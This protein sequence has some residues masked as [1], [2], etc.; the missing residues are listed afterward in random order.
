MQDMSTLELQKLFADKSCI[1]NAF[2]KAFHVIPSY[3]YIMFIYQNSFN[4]L[5]INIFDLIL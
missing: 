2:R 3:K 4:R 5:S 1:I